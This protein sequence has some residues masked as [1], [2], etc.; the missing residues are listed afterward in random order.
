MPVTSDLEDTFA[1]QLDAVGISYERQA[2]VIPGRKFQ[3]DFLVGKFLIEIQGGIWRK[4][5]HSTGVGITRDCEKANL[6]ALHGFFT[7]FFT[8]DMIYSGEALSVVEKA[9]KKEIV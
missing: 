7:L 8:A 9:M 1:F 2:K 3:W 5:G 6:A 4:G